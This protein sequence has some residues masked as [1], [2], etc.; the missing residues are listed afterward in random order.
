MSVTLTV[1]GPTGTSKSPGQ[2][3]SI[4]SRKTVPLKSWRLFYCFHSGEMLDCI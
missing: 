4:T 3:G 2:K 1:F